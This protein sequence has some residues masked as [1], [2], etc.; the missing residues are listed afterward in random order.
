MKVPYN[1]LPMQFADVERIISEWRQ[2][3]STTE[4]TLGPFVERFEKQF[5]EYL[6]VKHCISTNT[7]T[8][9]LILALKSVGIGN[10]DEVITVTNTFYATVGAIVATGAT[11]V[12]VDSDDRFQIDVDKIIPAVT[13]RTKAV[14]PVHWAGASPDLEALSTICSE[15]NIYLIEDACMGIGTSVS[16]KPAGTYSSV[17]GFSLHPLKSLHVMGDGG[18]TATNDDDLARWLK[19]YRN[20]GMVDRNHITMWGINNRLQPLQAV[21]ASIELESIDKTIRKRHKNAKIL[22]S[23]LSDLSDRI[24]LPERKN[25]NVENYSL[26]MGLFQERDLLRAYLEHFDIETKVHYPIPLHLQAA[27]SNLPYSKGDFPNS[28]KQAEELLTLP[29]HQYLEEEH[30]HYMINKIHD[31]Y[32]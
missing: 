21:V 7:G 28:E 31:F 10:G 1:Y 26:Y 19:T 22:D 3:I 18:M 24:F 29:V 25:S 17:S 32:D 16:G 6:G 27:A 13:N 12:F 20:H 9:A 14:I 5:S 15:H 8:D 4:F 23:G 30:L 2:L 11:P